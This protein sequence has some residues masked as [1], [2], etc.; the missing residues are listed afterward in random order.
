MKRG[1]PGS[2]RTDTLFPYTAL[3]RSLSE[4][5]AETVVV[6]S[7][8]DDKPADEC[9]SEK[10][11]WRRQERSLMGNPSRLHRGRPDGPPRASV[12]TRHELGQSLRMAHRPYRSDERRVGKE[13]V[14]TCSSR[15]APPQ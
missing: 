9:W 8:M 10:Q 1:P 13:C 3:F 5:P 11:P 12:I 2:T 14:S 4:V 15:W 6:R 7:S